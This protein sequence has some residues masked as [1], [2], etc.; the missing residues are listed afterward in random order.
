VKVSFSAI[1]PYLV[2]R[3]GRWLEDLDLQQP[4]DWRLVLL[5]EGRDIENPKASAR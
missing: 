1:A 4:H 5:T 2:S 3:E